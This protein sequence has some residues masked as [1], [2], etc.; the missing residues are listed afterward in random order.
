MISVLLPRVPLAGL[1][2]DDRRAK[3]MGA[4]SGGRAYAQSTY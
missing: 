3:L 1:R 2:H 4:E